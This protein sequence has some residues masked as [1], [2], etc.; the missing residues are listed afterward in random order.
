MAKARKHSFKATVYKTG[1]NF[2]VDVPE[3]ITSVL[4]AIKGYI[5]V[6]GI[7]NGFQ[8]RTTL[9]PVK[10]APYRL[11]TNIPMLKGA[12][13]GVGDIARFTIEQDV[14]VFEE[15]YPIPA[16]LAKK[17]REKKLTK[18][19]NELTMSRRKEILRYL[20]FIKTE[21]TLLCNIDKLI[22]R[23]EDSGGSARIP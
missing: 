17:L 10:N 21:E 6:K 4:E 22:S 18:A 15:E 20:S 7:I 23:M 12:K 1:I 11:F 3:G 19:F 5:K 9:V 13:A 16:M 14:E 2:A 8:F